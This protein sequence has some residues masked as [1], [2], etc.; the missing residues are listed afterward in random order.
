MLTGID[1]L[2]IAV[3]DVDAAAARL[4]TALGLRSTGGGR[5]PGQGTVNRLVWFGDSYLELIG[6]EDA[7]LAAG[8]WIGRPALDALDGS[9][10]GGF[11]TWAAATDDLADFGELEGPMDGER[12][13]PDGRVVRWR[14][15]R[16]GALGRDQPPFLIEHDV[17]AAEWTPEERAERA[18][19]RHPVGGPVRLTRLRIGVRDPVAAARRVGEVLGVDVEGSMVWIGPHEVVYV[20]LGHDPEATIELVVVAGPALRDLPREAV[21]FGCRFH[22]T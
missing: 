14:I 6:I 7:A 20:P 5:H 17:T 1:H 19:E 21:A 22:V 2:V 13:R 16:A 10:D 11:A 3:P 18:I 8:S 4:E 12:R 9:P 15:A